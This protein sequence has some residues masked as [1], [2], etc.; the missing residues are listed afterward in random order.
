MKPKIN[1][2]STLQDILNENPEYEL[3][4]NSYF[5]VPKNNPEFLRKYK[6]LKYSDSKR[7]V[8][9]RITLAIPR[10]LINL[11]VNLIGSVLLV[12]QYKYF[13]IR[14]KASNVLFISHATNNNLSGT[15]D[16]FFA[17]LPSIIG[18]QKSTILYLNHTKRRY[19]TNLFKLVQKSNCAN[20][21]LMPR[22]LRPKEFFMYISKCLEL[23]VAQI[24][25]AGKYRG[26]DS[27][28]SLILIHGIFWIFSR[29]SY[30]N[31]QISQRIKEINLQIGV[32]ILFLTLEG[33]S[34]EEITANLIKS[35]NEKAKI[36]LY[37]HSPITVAQKGVECFLQNL[38]YSVV[39]LTTG[40][41]YSR[42]LLQF[43]HR[44]D[45]FCIGSNKI[46]EMQ[47]NQFMNINTL[48]VAPEGT[49]LASNQF[50]RYLVRIARKYPNYNFI[51]RLHPNLNFNIFLILLKIRINKLINV[52]VSKQ[53]LLSDLQNSQATLYRSSAIAV[54][55][56][57][58][59]N[60][61][62]FVDFT[63]DLDLNV[64]SIIKTDF[65]VL[66]GNEAKL[67]LLEGLDSH[68]FNFTVLDELYLPF[69]ITE[70]L[71]EF[72]D[73]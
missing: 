51:L 62:L 72:I 26:N 48:L 25:I 1:L 73:K 13:N 4:F 20:V 60:V 12:G 70:E 17:N 50:M 33:H 32:E 21:L 54:E 64:Y 46:V 57:K 53:T 34:Y 2:A 49:A 67:H 28:K 45:V 42:F 30:N 40:P 43:S 31:Y 5:R 41:A 66:D 71:L 65:P 15:T 47:V 68:S 69:N 63:G 58:I 14:S 36:F 37:Q 10:I 29:E 6:S 8:V 9:I 52:R 22:F 19:T 7:T 27:L 59:H 39:L 3:L 56:L 55:T 61:P 23:L 11:A 44:N 16:V 38:K 24:R 35:N 18:K